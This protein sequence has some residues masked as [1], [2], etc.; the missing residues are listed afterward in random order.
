MWVGSRE[1]M[2]NRKCREPE[3][4][5]SLQALRENQLQ[6]WVSGLNRPLSSVLQLGWFG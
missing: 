1:K 3:Q 6:S 5:G 4:V 2:E